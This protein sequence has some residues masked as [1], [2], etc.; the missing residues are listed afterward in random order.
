MVSDPDRHTILSFDSHSNCVLFDSMNCTYIR[1]VTL[2]TKTSRILPSAAVYCRGRFWIACLN[3]LLVLEADTLEVLYSATIPAQSIAVVDDEQIWLGGDST[4][5]VLSTAD[6]SVLDR[7]SVPVPS[8][9]AMIRAGNQVWAACK[10]APKTSR[11]EFHHYDINTREHVSMFR[12][13]KKDVFALTV[14]DKTV[15]SVSES[16]CICAYDMETKECI[17]RISSHPVAF[18]ICAINDQIWFGTAEEIVIVDPKTF[19]CVGELHGYHT[20]SVVCTIPIVIDDRVE[21]WTGSLDKSVC[22]WSVTP[23]PDL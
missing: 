20:N 11:I 12:T 6:Y 1:S 10:D 15:W 23:L 8:V 13:D 14:Y 21:V 3:S 2:S 19:T 18:A 9:V 17:A 16:P 4:I 22:V 7:M 5:S